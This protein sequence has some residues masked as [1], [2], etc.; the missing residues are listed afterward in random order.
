VGEREKIIRKRFVMSKGK[1]LNQ[2][3]NEEFILEI[4]P[5]LA[6]EA[7]KVGELTPPEG[8]ERKVEAF[9][10]AM[11][12]ATERAEAN[13]QAA[14]GTDLLFRKANKLAEAYGLDR[15]VS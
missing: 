14:I 11:E 10:K 12:E 4:I 5:V 2:A 8:G 3:D 13:P 7:Q 1:P 6:A 9:V 15:C